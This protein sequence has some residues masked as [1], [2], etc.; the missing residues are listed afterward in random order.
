MSPRL[1]RLI[2]FGMPLA[3][4]GMIL[5]CATS[6]N[7]VPQPGTVLDEALAAQRN[8]AALPAADEDS[9]HKPTG[10]VGLRL[11]PNPAFDA[12]AAGKW[13]PERYYTDPK[14]YLSKDLVKPYR[15]GMSC[16]FCHVGPNP[17]NPPADP[18][19]PEWANLSSN[20]G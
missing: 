17:I 20:V 16:G 4:T 13:D 6:C 11:L 9:Y 14:Y 15:V 10:V 8:A 18:E 12:A 1:F 19:K 5:I 2:T 7:S 3:M